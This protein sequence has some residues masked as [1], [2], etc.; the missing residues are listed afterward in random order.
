MTL[1]TP[2]STSQAKQEKQLQDE[3]EKRRRKEEELKR[4]HDDFAEH[5]AKTRTRVAISQER[6][7]MERK[8]MFKRL[9]NQNIAA[10]HRKV[11]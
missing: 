8:E 3:A 7:E 10:D 1:V 9:Q 4:K 5:E 11:H 6:A 2:C